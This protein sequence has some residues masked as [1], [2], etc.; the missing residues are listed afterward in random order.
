MLTLDPGGRQY[1]LCTV[2]CDHHVKSI[3]IPLLYSA[4]YIDCGK[5]LEKPGLLMDPE[6]R[7]SRAWLDGHPAR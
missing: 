7:D 4:A 2:V 3:Q 1:D 5:F 6:W